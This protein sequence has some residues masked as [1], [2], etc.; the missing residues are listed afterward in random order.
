LDLLAEERS[1]RARRL[2]IEHKPARRNREA[3]A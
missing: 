1:E 2:G 3:C